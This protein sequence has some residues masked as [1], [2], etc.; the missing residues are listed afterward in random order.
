MRSDP[1]PEIKRALCAELVRAVEGAR[2]VYVADMLGID[3]NRVTELRAGAL[4]RF[5]TESLIRFLDRAG[6]DVRFT[7]TKRGG[8]I[9]RAR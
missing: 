1:I 9:G 2:Q 6:Y 8:R 5:S 3:G 4:K 7:A